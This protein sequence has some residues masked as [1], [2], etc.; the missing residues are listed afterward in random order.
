V[1]RTDLVFAALQVPLDYLA[2]VVAGWAAYALRFNQIAGILPVTDPMPYGAY[3]RTVWVV[4]AIWLGVLGLAGAYTVRQQRLTTELARIFLGVSTAVLLIIVAIFFRREFFTSRF[5]ILAGWVLSIGFLWLTHGL[6]RFIR[7]QMLKRGVGARQA[8]IVGN[9]QL[10][11]DLLSRLHTQPRLGLRVLRH[12]TVCTS[13]QLH[14]LADLFEQRAVDLVIQSD[15][16]LPR[17]QTLELIDV[18]T[19]YSVPFHY[20]A[21]IFDSQAA[22]M[23]MDEVAGMPVMVLKRTPLDGWGRIFKRAF[24][25]VAAGLGVVILT[26]PTLLVAVLI[27]LDSAGS[28][29]VRLERVGEGQKRFYLWK[30]RSMVRDAHALKPQLMDRNERADG[31][32]FKISDDPRITRIG[33]WLR[34]TSVDELPQLL[35][36]IKGEMSLVG[37]RP[38]EPEEVARYEKHHK[39]LLTIKPGVTGM[40]Q[41]SGRSNLSFEDEVRLD[42]FYIEHWSLGLDLQ[43]IMRT[44]AAVLQT[45]TAA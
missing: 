17:S 16:S 36:V 11:V 1:K 41:I 20:A 27:K 14:E 32:L 7:W 21:D 44:P 5:I 8:V 43:I 23:E 22:R 13:D 12:Y 45:K 2:L 37:P 39:K 6:L 34:K 9:D 3:L 15:V 10:T 18:C 29:F 26:I 31:P 33:K 25:L 30:F 4:A 38:H 28:I 40:A 24:D 19:E 42:T 35:N